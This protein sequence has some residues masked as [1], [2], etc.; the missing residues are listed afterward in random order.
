M[1]RVEQGNNLR[2]KAEL[3]DKSNR[4]SDISNQY[5]D[6]ISGIKEMINVKDEELRRLSAALLVTDV[7]LIRL[8]VVN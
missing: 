1:L 5:E 6:Q 3:A 8:K 4:L 7:D 2:L